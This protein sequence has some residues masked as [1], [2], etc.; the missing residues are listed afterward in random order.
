MKK[1]LKIRSISEI[2]RYMGIE[3]PGHPLVSV[4]RHNRETVANFAEINIV[5]DFYFILMK[6]GISGSFK[7]GRSRYDFNDGT[8]IF[9]SPGQVI[10]APDKSEVDDSGEGWSLAF[11]PDLIRRFELGKTIDSYSFFN[12]EV[13]EALHLSEKEKRTLS[14]LVRKIEDEVVQSIDKHTQKLIVSNIELILDY[15][16]RFYDRQFYVRSDLSCDVVTQFRKFLTA[17]FASQEQLE[18]GL[19]T[20]R[21]CGENLGVSPN[22]LSDLLKKETGRNAQD[23]IHTFIIEK[24]KTLLLS[25]N[26]T[27]SEI[28]FG[29]GFEYSQHF[30]RL[31]KSKTGMTPKEYRNI[32]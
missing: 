28:A 2:H 9:V 13:D 14:E 17:Y 7:Y 10:S 1:F 8:M 20:V 11:H 29:L 24:A 12:Y 26:N 16:T 23:H 4:F 22:Y 30:S 19:P 5:T 25:T 21:Y 31:F 32:N 6:E 3:N 27:V 15:C 18:N